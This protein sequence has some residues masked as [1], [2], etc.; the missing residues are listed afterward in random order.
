MPKGG[1][2]DVGAG[3][4]LAPEAAGHVEADKAIYV[5]SVAAAMVGMHP[6]TLRAYERKGLL[7]PART[8]G[9]SRRY[10]QRDIETLLR[11]KVLTEEG[12]NIEG[13]RRVLELEREVERLRDKVRD[14][15]ARLAQALSPR[16]P[17]FAIVPIPKK[18]QM[19]IEPVAIKR[20]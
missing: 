6:Q 17:G 9:G 5:M 1:A 3:G 4:W 10:S 18:F 14:L 19:A 12:L 2:R 16:G 11:I 15:E 20:R 7:D 13:V 8:K